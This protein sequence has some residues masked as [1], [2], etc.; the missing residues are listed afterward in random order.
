[1]IISIVTPVYNGEN[2]IESCIQVAIAQNCSDIEHIIVDG[3]SSDRTVEIIKKYAQNYPHI[4]WISEKD[5][6]QSDALN[7]GIAMAKGDI[8]AILNVDDF[9]EPNVLNRVLEIFKTL[10]NPSLVV[11]NCNILGEGDRL[12]NVQK[13]SKLTLYDFIQGYE[14][15]SP[16]ANPSAYFYHKSLHQKIGLYKLEENYAM[17]TDFLFRAVQVANIKYVDETWGN[18]RYVRGTKSFDNAEAGNFQKEYQKLIRSYIKDLPM[19]QRISM[20]W[21]WNIL[22]RMQYFSRYPEKSFSLLLKKIKSMVN[23]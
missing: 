7:K 10:P 1:M 6:G 13:P 8:L 21:K 14:V 22:T 19:P 17:D 5:K 9:Y 23:I 3:G 20:Y 15:S 18:F 16:P 11:G 12:I 2:F 4:R